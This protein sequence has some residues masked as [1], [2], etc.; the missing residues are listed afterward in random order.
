MKDKTSYIIVMESG[1]QMGG[2]SKY[3]GPYGTIELAT[4]TFKKMSEEDYYNDYYIRR[5][6]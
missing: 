5:I 3:Y 2:G 1:D 4:A 6:L